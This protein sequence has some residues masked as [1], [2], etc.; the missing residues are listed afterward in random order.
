MR[1]TRAT[2]CIPARLAS[3]RLPDKVL[4]SDTGRPLIEYAIREARRCQLVQ[5]VVV[6]TDS[7]KVAEAVS[8]LAVVW[9]DP[10]DASW[11]GTQRVA[12]ALLKLPARYADVDVI[13]NWQADEPE[14][15]FEDVDRLVA[16]ADDNIQPG[17]C[18]FCTITAPYSKAA[19]ATP[20]VTKAK[21]DKPGS[22]RIM[23]FVRQCD[24]RQ[25]YRPHVGIYAMRPAQIAELLTETP[26]PRSIADSLEQLTWLDLGWRCE[27]IGI[28]YTPQGINDAAD[29]RRF[30]AR[31]LED[32]NE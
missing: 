11:C 21:H 3:K 29:Y 14:L 2:V 10:N 6:A 18:D 27:G 22:R 16:Y 30:V 4:L 17:G 7:M 23:D 28:T 12:Q 20:T 32:R 24:G 9:L 8:G 31:H 5:H 19:C 13:V 1:N 26:S 15:M 25:L